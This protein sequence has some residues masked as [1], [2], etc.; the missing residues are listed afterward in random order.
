MP[1]HLTVLGGREHERIGLVTDREHDRDVLVSGLA[2]RGHLD[3]ERCVALL[4]PSR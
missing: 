1:D 2:E 3:R 4:R